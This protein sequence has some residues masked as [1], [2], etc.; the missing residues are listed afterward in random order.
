MNTWKNDNL[1]IK[2]NEGENIDLYKKKKADYERMEGISNKA[3]YTIVEKAKA[4]LEPLQNLIRFSVNGYVFFVYVMIEDR[5][6]LSTYKKNHPEHK[7]DL[8]ASYHFDF[9]LSYEENISKAKEFLVN[10]YMESIQPEVP[11]VTASE[12]NEDELRA[13]RRMKLSSREDYRKASWNRSKNIDTDSKDSL[14]GRPAVEEYLN[15]LKVG[16]KVSFKTKSGY[17]ADGEITKVKKTGS[18]EVKN[19]KGTTVTV[20][21]DMIHPEFK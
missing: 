6:I 11:E 10:A 9:N 18:F 2:M 1:L 12:L 19:S 16:D 8:D 4:D 14:Y 3:A 13:Y 17:W 15:D 21:R 7:Y 20:T 5:S